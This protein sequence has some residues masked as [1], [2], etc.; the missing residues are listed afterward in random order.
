ML[1]LDWIFAAVLLVSFLLGAWRGLI[2]EVL[3]VLTWLVAFLLAQWF[4]PDMAQKLPMSGADPT[5]RYAAGFV[6]V[7]VI[8]VFAGGLL[9]RLVQKLFAVVGLQ[10][11]DRALGAMF[12][13]LRGVLVVL[14]ATVVLSMTPLKASVWWQDS[15]LAGVS[16]LALK[17]LKPVLPEE[18]GKYL[19]A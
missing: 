13:L 19:P 16:V 5:L 14:A 17:S 10:P 2:Y 9:S 15:V 3:S 4:A 18:F 11:A 8:V 12:G 7:F 6:L 1:G